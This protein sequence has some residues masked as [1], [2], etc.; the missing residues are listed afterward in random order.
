MSIEIT[1]TESLPKHVAFEAVVNDTVKVRMIRREME[2]NTRSN[3]L[4]A[5]SKAYDVADVFAA[6]LVALEPFTD[7]AIPFKP[8]EAADK[9]RASMWSAWK[10]ETMKAA[11]ERLQAFLDLLERECD[12]ISTSF[13]ASHR[14]S[15]KAG[16]SCGCSPAFLL[17]GHVKVKDVLFPVDIHFETVVP[18]KEKM[19]ADIEELLKP[20][21]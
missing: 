6:E 11:G 3:V 20:V 8:E 12:Q 18:K 4:W 17:G 19:I 14:F 13:D 21:N 5:K 10:R 2:Y 15:H 9:V 16:C 7:Y 1:A